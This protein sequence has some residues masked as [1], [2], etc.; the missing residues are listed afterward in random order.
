MAIPLAHERPLP[1][2]LSETDLDI[3]SR[4]AMARLPAMP[5]ILV[6]LM[7]YCQAEDISIP[8]LADLIAKDAAMTAIILRVAN[9]ASSHRRSPLANLEQSLMVIGID[10]VKTL[11]IS[12]SVFQLF[13]NIS[14]VSG[15]NLRGFWKHSLTAAITARLIAEQMGDVSI[16]EAYFAG[17]LHDVG[18]LALLAI[19]PKTYGQS[20]FAPDDDDLCALERRT[21]QTTHA[22]VGASLIEHWKLD[23]FL[24]DSVLYHHDP[25]E[26]LE[27]A[28]SLV[29]IVCLTHHL[30]TPDL[31]PQLQAAATLCGLTVEDLD[32]ITQ[33]AAERVVVAAAHLGI[34]LDD[35]DVIPVPA[36]AAISAPA[37][38][39]AKLG[40]G[41][42]VSNLVLTTELRR[43][44]E[45]QDA[46]GELQKAIARSAIMLFNFSDATLF[47]V[48]GSSQIL[49][50]INTGERHQRL[51]EFSIPLAIKGP[52]AQAAL[53]R[54]VA[55]V[56]RNETLVGISEEQLHRI[57]DA[58]YLVCVPLCDKDRCTGVL[59]GGAKS[60]QLDDIRKRDSFLLA[61]GV[62]AANA[63]N[64]NATAPRR[65]LSDFVNLTEQYQ[66][67]S[68]R[69]AHEVNNPLSII[70][71]YLSVL[72][73]KL[74]RKEPID[75]E[76]SI[77]NE[78]IDRV[79][80]LIHDFAEQK[81]VAASGPT[82]VNAVIDDV[83]RL[84]SA[85]EYFPHSVNIV[86]QT[87][88]EACEVEGDIGSLK[89]VLMNLI[90]NAV[91]ALPDGG[92]IEIG[93]N[94]VVNRE[95]RLY[96]ELWIRDTGP[97]ISAAMMRNLFS[98][99]LS[100]KGGSHR[101]LGLSV[102]HSLMTQMKGFI[103]CRTGRKGTTFELLIPVPR[104]SELRPADR[105]KLRTLA[106]Q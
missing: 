94:G 77:L 68:K 48:D 59:V 80:K 11:L 8:E 23:S 55:I 33:C 83:V 84:F 25:V 92:E 40:L 32:V 79:G 54:R 12:E 61:F 45:K 98:P 69:V 95:G 99:V 21:L 44:W 42:Q 81:P 57:L 75:S 15:N 88:D 63:L 6:K 1:M 73:R 106:P 97:G 18:R 41:Q 28:P 10:M 29:R 66:Q 31:R 35:V 62:H 9:S 87:P 89:Q 78:E 19:V 52:I 5:Q 36:A 91:E 34:D 70:K 26:R 101:G 71:N 20:F 2:N 93:N 38:D 17:L 96:G 105:V 24:A 46:D 13:D 39:A 100:T 37:S 53:Q 14:P 86:V 50:G 4:L 102:V 27:N 104:P 103:H 60:W 43:S 16:E 65:A 90:K 72:D 30:T 47:L 85:T 67:A 58:E 7:E 64:A 76:L 3:H 74:A 51:S 82:E 49:K 22:E 56:D